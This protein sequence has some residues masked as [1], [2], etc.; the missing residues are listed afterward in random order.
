MRVEDTLTRGLRG[1]TVA[2]PCRGLL[3]N[4]PVVPHDDRRWSVSTRVQ[5]GAQAAAD[6]RNYTLVQEGWPATAGAGQAD[7]FQTEA[8]WLVFSALTQAVADN[9][10]LKDLLAT[11]T[12]ALNGAAARYATSAATSGA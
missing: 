11:T 6:W 10:P 9:A 3:G 1:L 4:A 7:P 8:E 12:E 2:S 5:S